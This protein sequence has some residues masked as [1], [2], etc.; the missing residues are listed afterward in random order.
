MICGMVN[1]VTDVIILFYVHSQWF[2]MTYYLIKSMLV[3]VVALP[4]HYNSLFLF[5][6]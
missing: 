6:S 3:R 1:N 2:G 4:T 5:A